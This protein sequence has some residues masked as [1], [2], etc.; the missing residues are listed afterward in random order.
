MGIVLQEKMR[1]TV[2]ANLWAWR[3]AGSLKGLAGTLPDGLM[4]GIIEQQNELWLSTSNSNGTGMETNTFHGIVNGKII[5]LT[6]SPGVPDGQAV[7]VVI[8]PATGKSACWG[9]GLRRCAGVLADE[10]TDE[11]DRILEAI[12]QERQQAKS[13]ELPE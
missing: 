8:S 12:Q 4:S 10:W 9:D 5:Q 7:E 13:R 3:P 1:A 6:E 2:P 11:D